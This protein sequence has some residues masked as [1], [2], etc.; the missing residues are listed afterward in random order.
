MPWV[1]MAIILMAAFWISRHV[2]KII[3]YIKR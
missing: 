3:D 2:V 1:G